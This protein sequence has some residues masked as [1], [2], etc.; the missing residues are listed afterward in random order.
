M[1]RIRFNINTTYSTN[2]PVIVKA[3]PLILHWKKPPS[4]DRL[5]FRDIEPS[6]NIVSKK[7]EDPNTLK[8]AESLGSQI[9]RIG[10]VV[11]VIGFLSIFMSF[12]SFG[13]PSSAILKVVRL[14]KV[15]SR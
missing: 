14:F 6:I 5:S 2:K 4:Q 10:S 12:L 8:E 1:K 9:E 11:E 7:P 3:K 15:I 13:G